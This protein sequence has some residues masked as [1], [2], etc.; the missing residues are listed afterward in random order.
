[1]GCLM[2]HMLP[3][4]VSVITIFFTIVAEL[5]QHS[6]PV[7]GSTAAAQWHIKA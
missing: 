2:P 7:G 3:V 4:A 1:M 5:R 6:S